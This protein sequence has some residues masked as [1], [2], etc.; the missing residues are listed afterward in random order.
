M[1]VIIIGASAL[2][3]HLAQKLVNRGNQVIMI[4]S[5]TK[6]AKELAESLDCT[7]INAEGTRPDILE[8]AEIEKADAIVACTDHDQDNILIG[9]I[10]RNYK[11]Q[12]IILR[13]HDT[14]FLVVAKKLGFN[15]LINPSQIASSIISD[16]LRDVDTIELSSLVRGDVRFISVLATTK[17]IDR[18]LDEVT[19]PPKSAFIG[20]YRGD[21]FILSGENPVVREG[22]EAVIITTA[23]QVNKIREFFSENEVSKTK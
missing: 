20:I 14:Q 7:I 1:R 2:G 17:Q 16:T 23:D 9:L 19:L 13:I 11:V 10:A 5:E 3:K 12:K 8:K 21:E 15:D 4:E 18:R 6:Y 22:D